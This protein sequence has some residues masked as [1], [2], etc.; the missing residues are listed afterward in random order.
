MAT[1]V[2]SVTAT[3]PIMV[4]AMIKF[5]VPDEGIK[6]F[7][8]RLAILVGTGW[9]LANRRFY[10]MVHRPQWQV[11]NLDNL[12]PD[13]CYLIM[14]NHQS[15]TDIAVLVFLLVGRTSPLKFFLKQEL[16]WLPFVGIACWVLDF[17]FMKR[18]SKERLEANPELRIQDLERTRR[19]CEKLQHNPGSVINYVEGT[20]FTPEKH[21]AQGSP[22]RYLLKPK[23]GG[24]AYVI[25]TIGDQI[26]ELLDVTI[27]YRGARQDFF[28]FLS[29]QIEPI[30]V[31]I[32]ERVIP[33]NILA[34]DYQKSEAFRAEFQAW[35]AQLWREKDALIAAH[36][37]RK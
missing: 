6:S 34:G 7:C 2:L 33:E 4:L 19:F 14:S 32:K 13:H 37:D 36:L 31:D 3:V 30:I 22:Y 18:Y 27:V 1:L 10:F 29:G 24:M 17:P 20:R 26:D 9:V 15:W 25:G 28:G 21:K 16:I 5:L 23:S 12:S 8:S 35:I 11:S